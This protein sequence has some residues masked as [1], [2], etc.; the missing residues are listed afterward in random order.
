MRCVD[1]IGPSAVRGARAAVAAAP[2]RVSSAGAVNRRDESEAV[3]IDADREVSRR[4]DRRGAL[5]V[6][7]R[8]GGVAGVLAPPPM[9]VDRSIALVAVTE[10]GVA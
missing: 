8:R 4:V 10:V 1:R 7:R 5:G 3:R 6:A 2:P 9:P